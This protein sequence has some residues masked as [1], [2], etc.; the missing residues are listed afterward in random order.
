[1]G[2]FYE[3]LEKQ[4]SRLLEEASLLA[5]WAESRDELAWQVRMLHDLDPL[6]AMALLRQMNPDVHLHGL[7]TLDD[8]RKYSTAVGPLRFFTDDDDACVSED[9]EQSPSEA[10]N[11]IV[12]LA[13]YRKR[14]SD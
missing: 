7:N 11:K 13:D 12:D 9:N 5:I 4:P 1:M 6:R 10:A 3:V 2:V 14:S 8:E